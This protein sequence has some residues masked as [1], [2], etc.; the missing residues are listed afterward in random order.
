MAK[1]MTSLSGG[2][3]GMRPSLL[4]PHPRQTIKLRTGQTVP[5]PPA[6]L[7]WA[8][9]IELRRSTV[10]LHYR[11]RSGRVRQPV[12]PVTRVAQLQ[13]AAKE[14]LLPLPNPFGRAAMGKAEKEFEVSL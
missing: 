3:S 10:R 8:Q 4:P 9:V 13:A 2:G 7:G 6:P 5:W 1:Q 14:L 11:C 12:A